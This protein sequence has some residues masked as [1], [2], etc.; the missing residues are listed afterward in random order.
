[1]SIG[2]RNPLEPVEEAADLLARRQQAREAEQVSDNDAGKEK[3][4]RDR[5]WDA[6]RSKATYDLPPALI[7]RIRALADELTE[8]Y[9]DARVRI[10]DVVRLLLEAGLAEYEAGHISVELKPVSFVIF[11]D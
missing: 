3:K 2:R 10:S 7:D 6:Q 1:M 4:G 8:A 5:S 9:P 11:D